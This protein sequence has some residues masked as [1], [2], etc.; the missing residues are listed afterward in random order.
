MRRFLQYVAAWLP[1]GPLLRAV[2]SPPTPQRRPGA[3]DVATPGTPEARPAVGFRCSA[4]RGSRRGF[5]AIDR[6][7]DLSALSGAAGL[8]PHALTAAGHG[9]MIR[10]AHLRQ[11]GSL[12]L[13]HARHATVTACLQ[14]QLSALCWR[15]RCRSPRDRR[16]RHRWLSPE[17]KMC[18]LGWHRQHAHHAP[19]MKSP[20]QPP[21]PAFVQRGFCAAARRRTLNSF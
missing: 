7:V 8:H 13:P 21:T 5:N 16:V 14:A 9:T 19:F 10:S 11:N 1:Q 12:L 6:A 18:L 20:Y 15:R 4:A 3:A 2:A 17:P